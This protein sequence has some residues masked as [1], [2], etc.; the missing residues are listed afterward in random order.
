MSFIAVVETI[1][2]NIV[3]W[4][5]R[6]NRTKRKDCLPVL[7][8]WGHETFLLPFLLLGVIGVEWVV[9]AVVWRNVRREIINFCSYHASALKFALIILY[10]FLRSV[11]PSRST[12]G[13]VAEIEGVNQNPCQDR[14]AGRSALFSLV[15]SL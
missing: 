10:V 6:R 2:T 5:A 12:K 3:K 1:R 11:H 7:D 13:S 9:G 4:K 15:L 8:Q 14:N